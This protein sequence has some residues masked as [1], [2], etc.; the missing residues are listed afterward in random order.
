MRQ[1][2]EAR[3]TDLSRVVIDPKH[4]REQRLE[5]FIRQTGDPYHLKVGKI[6][7]EL[8]FDESQPSLEQKLAEYLSCGEPS[9]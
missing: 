2:A 1:A 4:T 8:C 7:V 6:L 3:Y 5:A 9:L